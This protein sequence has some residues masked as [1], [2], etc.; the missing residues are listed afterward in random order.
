MRQNPTPRRY[1][2]HRFRA[3]KQLEFFFDFIF[4]S[5][6]F[7]HHTE[8]QQKIFKSIQLEHLQLN[9]TTYTI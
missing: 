2:A 8:I 1:L 6:F 4:I 3:F 9:S 5:S 7:H